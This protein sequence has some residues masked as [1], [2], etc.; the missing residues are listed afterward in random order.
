MFIDPQ[1]QTVHEEYT[2]SPIYV[3]LA[4][5]SGGTHRLGADGHKQQDRDDEKYCSLVG[6]ISLYVSYVSYQ[7]FLRPLFKTTSKKPSET[8]RKC[9]HQLCGSEMFGRFSA[10]FRLA[11]RN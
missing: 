1:H 11:V 6:R 4:K 5:S 3:T 8:I 9:C 7:Q 2:T 10:I